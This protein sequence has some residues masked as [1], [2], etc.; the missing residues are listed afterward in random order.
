MLPRSKRHVLF[1]AAGL[2]EVVLEVV[3]TA[4]SEV[5][6]LLGKTCTP[7]ARHAKLVAENRADP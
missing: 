5:E 7:G 6:D 2:V 3:V 4:T 1:S